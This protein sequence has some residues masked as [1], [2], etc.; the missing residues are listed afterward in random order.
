MDFDELS[1]NLAQQQTRD[2]AILQYAFYKNV[3]DI[4]GDEE[5][6]LEQTELFIRAMIE[7]ATDE[8]Q[9]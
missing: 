8:D 4:C 6:A 2:L 5:R 9:T 1:S 7:S 3:L